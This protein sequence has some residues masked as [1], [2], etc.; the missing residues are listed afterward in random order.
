[1]IILYLILAHLIGDFVLQPAKLVQWK[2]KSITG[3]AVHTLI[4]FAVSLILIFPYLN[5]ETA[6]IVLLL[7]IVHALID[8]AKISKSLKS[9]KFVAYFVIDQLLHLI[10][11]IGAGVWIF[12]LHDWQKQ[13]W[14]LPEIYNNHLIALFLILIVFMGY[15]VEIYKHTKKMHS[16]AEGMRFDYKEIFMRILALTFVYIIFTAAAYLI[17]AL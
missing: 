11:V 5:L 13:T 16:I 14:F 7:A 4:H 8:L 1:M 3:I 2:V 12:Y 9:D 10:T 17:T 6:A 15:T